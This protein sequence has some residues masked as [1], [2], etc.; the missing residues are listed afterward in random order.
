MAQQARRQRGIAI[1]HLAVDFD[2][3]VRAL[4]AVG[5]R[6]VGA[7]GQTPGRLVPQRRQRAALA[8]CNERANFL[9]EPQNMLPDA[10]ALAAARGGVEG[11]VDEPR[12]GLHEQAIGAMG[13]QQQRKIVA[14]LVEFAVAGEKRRTQIQSVDGV[15]MLVRA[16]ARQE[17]CDVCLSIR[18]HVFIN[19]PC[20]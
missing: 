8:A 3:G 15:Q 11:A 1:R 10:L 5:E 4:Q 17:K 2:G 9:L 18:F 20:W 7:L 19:L 16:P 13:D 12:Q 14:Q 6:F